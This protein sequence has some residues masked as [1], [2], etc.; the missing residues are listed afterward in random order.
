MTLPEFAD[1]FATLATQLRATDADETTIRSYYQALKDL[2]LELVAAAAQRLSKSAEWFPK[3]SEWRLAVE[4]VWADRVQEQRAL[5][6][7]AKEPLCAACDDTGWARVSSVEKGQPV[8]RVRR[9]ACVDERYDE[10]LGRRPMPRLLPATVIDSTQE[11]QAL[12]MARKA[13][14]RW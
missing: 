1:V 11:A 10:L 2:E 7:N 3:T 4:R 13:V 5:L 6:R 14:K 9:C 8:T 12:E